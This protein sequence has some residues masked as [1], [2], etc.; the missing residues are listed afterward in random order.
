MTVGVACKS[1]VHFSTSFSTTRTLFRTN[2]E[3]GLLQGR[4]CCMGVPHQRQ[5]WRT[6]GADGDWRRLAV[7]FRVRN[8]Q[9]TIKEKRKWHKK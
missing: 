2:G 1:T 6:A 5:W 3:L 9:S 8:L 7:Q 4:A